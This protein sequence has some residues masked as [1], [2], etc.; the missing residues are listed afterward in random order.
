MAVSSNEKPAPK[1]KHSIFAATKRFMCY[2]SLNPAHQTRSGLFRIACSV[3]QQ[4]PV[5][6][7]VHALPP[8]P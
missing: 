6:V 5:V 4:E 7:L 8:D 3:Q 1:A 2:C